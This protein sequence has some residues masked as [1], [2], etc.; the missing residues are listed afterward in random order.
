MRKQTLKKCFKAEKTL[1][2]LGKL[3]C[4]IDEKPAIVCLVVKR[5]DLQSRGRGFNP[6]AWYYMI[7]LH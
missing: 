1:R 2:L 4:E 6:S 3:F 5:E 7:L